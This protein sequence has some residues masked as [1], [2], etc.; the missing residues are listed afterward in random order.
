MNFL[1]VPGAP[2]HLEVTSVEKDSVT[3][4]WKKPKD[5]GGS[6][7]TVYIIEKCEEKKQTWTKVKEVDHFV[8]S[9][10]VKSLVPETAYYFRVS[11]KNNI[12]IGEP[13]ELRSPV[14]PSRPIGEFPFVFLIY[15]FNTLHVFI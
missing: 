14:I 9:C 4:H 15:L 10:Q 13:A 1:D 5:D 3:L 2:D 7:I 6:S 12:G 8:H 11:A